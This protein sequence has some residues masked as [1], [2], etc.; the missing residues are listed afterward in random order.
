[1]MIDARASQ[2]PSIRM[3]GIPSL[4]NEDRVSSSVGKVKPTRKRMIPQN[5][6][7]YLVLLEPEAL[8]GPVTRASY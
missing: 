3:K 4:Y 5:N 2:D 8:A 1:M 7:K 6:L